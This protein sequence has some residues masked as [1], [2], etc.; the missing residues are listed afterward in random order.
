MNLSAPPYV[1]AQRRV[2][3]SLCD[4]IKDE[5]GDVESRGINSKIKED[6]SASLVCHRKPNGKLRICLDPKDLH[7]AI[8]Y[9]RASRY[10]FTGRSSSKAKWYQVFLYC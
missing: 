5:L 2:Q 6:E 1:Y 9:Q 4:D 10:L 3:L 7:K 8:H